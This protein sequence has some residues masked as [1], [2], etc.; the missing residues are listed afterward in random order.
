[1]NKVYTSLILVFGLVVLWTIYLTN[2]RE[3]K[4]LTVR[5]YTIKELTME[6]KSINKI[7]IGGLVK[8]NSIDINESNRLEVWFYVYQ[9]E[10]S[11][12]V[13][14]NGTR[15]DLFKDDAEI[16]ISGKFEN[17]LITATELQTKCASRYEGDL[18]NINST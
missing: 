9:G 5:Y 8:P 1:M 4:N 6:E 18:K 16:V 7:K 13:Y 11:L 2:V 10:D 15:P 17:N 14:Y 3:D 12:K